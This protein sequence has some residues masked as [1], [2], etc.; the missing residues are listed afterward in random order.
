VLTM[1]NH[2]TQVFYALAA[3]AFMVSAYAGAGA[4]DRAAERAADACQCTTDSECEG[5]EPIGGE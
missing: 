1:R 3:A 2:M 5:I 4:L